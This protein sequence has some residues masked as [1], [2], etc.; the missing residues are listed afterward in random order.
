MSILIRSQKADRTKLAPM[1]YFTVVAHD[2][3]AV[4]ISVQAGKNHSDGLK[5]ESDSFPIPHMASH[6]LGQEHWRILNSDTNHNIKTTKEFAVSI[7]SE[8]FLEASNYTAIDAPGDVDE[9]K[10]SGLTKRRSE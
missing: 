10:L 2:P 6:V 5:G 7:I 4:M 8:P 1:S 9:W 3:P